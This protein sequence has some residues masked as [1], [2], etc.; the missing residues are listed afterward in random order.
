MIWQTG[1][2]GRLPSKGQNYWETEFIMR[3]CFIL[4]WGSP[5]SF[6][7]GTQS[8]WARLP[9]TY[10]SFTR[11]EENPVHTRSLWGNLLVIVYWINSTEKVLPMSV[12]S[13]FTSEEA[14]QT[15]TERKDFQDTSPIAYLWADTPCIVHLSTPIGVSPSRSLVDSDQEGD[16]KS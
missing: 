9:L 6:S 15:C 4:L 5:V 2:V 16:V 14:Y 11:E 1:Q 8:R 12:S 7:P 3:G 10:V 13:F